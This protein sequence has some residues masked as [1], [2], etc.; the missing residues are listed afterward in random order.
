MDVSQNALSRR[1]VVLAALFSMTPL[2]QGGLIVSFAGVGGLAGEAEFTLVNSTTLQVRI[3]NTSTGV[4]MGFSN[5]DQLLTSVAFDLPGAITITGGGAV[6]GPTSQSVNFDSGSYGPG[7]D[8]GGEWGFGNTG[9]TN[10]GTLVNLISGNSAHATAF[11]GSDLDGPDGLDGPQAGL[12]SASAPVAL[13]GLGAIQDEIIATITLSSAISDLSFL[14]S[15]VIMEFGSD[16]AFLT[17]TV[18][19]P[20]ALALLAMAGVV[21]RRRRRPAAD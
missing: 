4:P 11:G 8:V 19:A 16:A 5:S 13:G 20:G 10:F 15:G 2:V 1:V 9:G 14:N 21:G 12:Y 7:F 18:P 6:I 17:G 3:R